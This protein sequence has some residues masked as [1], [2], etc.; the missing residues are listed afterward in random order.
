MGI[1]W[2]LQLSSY[3]HGLC[4]RSVCSDVRCNL[5]CWSL[6]TRWIFAMLSL[7]VACFVWLLLNCMWFP[8]CSLH[9]RWIFVI[10]SHCFR[11]F[12]GSDI[13]KNMRWGCYGKNN[14]LRPSSQQK[15]CTHN[16]ENA[17]DIVTHITP[18]T[19]TKINHSS[20]R[21]DHFRR[22]LWGFRWRYFWPIPYNLRCIVVALP[23]R[24]R[25][26]GLKYHENWRKSITIQRTSNERIKNIQ[27]KYKEYATKVIWNHNGNQL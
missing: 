5:V 23:C 13:F 1:S 16:T 3:T 2:V 11:I 22:L 18:R 17:Q 25:T 20:W 26:S 12:C 14:E 6:H 19:T 21:D 10:D 27:R 8:W 9:V 15:H 4:H 7:G 24:P